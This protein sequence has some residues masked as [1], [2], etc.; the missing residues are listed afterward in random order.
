M[1]FL[2]KHWQLCPWR[3]S[4]YSDR[5]QSIHCRPIARYKTLSH[6]QLTVYY[7]RGIHSL[8]AVFCCFCL[9]VL[10]IRSFSRLDRSSNDNVCGQLLYYATAVWLWTIRSQHSQQYRHSRR[11][12]FF[13]SRDIDLWPFD[14][15]I[16]GFPD[17]I[18]EHFYV[19]FDDPSCIGFYRTWTHVH[20]RHMLSSFVYLSVVVVFLSVC[21]VRAPYSAGWNFRQFF[22]PFGTLAIHWHPPKILRRSSL[23][24][25]SMGGGVKRKRGSQ[26]YRFLEFGMLYLRNSAM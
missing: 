7:N 15:E 11:Q 25:P 10:L 17:L 26:I 4:I 23:G 24:N 3:L 1:C 13:V 16:S 8:R 20:V 6:H 19:N 12:C 2:L 21:N 18:V 9:T 5:I 14:P 22:S